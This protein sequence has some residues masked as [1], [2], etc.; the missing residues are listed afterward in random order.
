MTV[1]F[2]NH[3]IGFYGDFTTFALVVPSFTI[4]CA[5]GPA[6]NGGPDVIRCGNIM[7]SDIIGGVQ[8]D[9]LGGQS[10]ATKNGTMSAQAYC[11]EM[12][13]VQAFSWMLFC[14]NAIAL[15]ILFRLVIQAQMFGRFDIWNEP[16]RAGTCSELPWFGEAPGFYNTHQ[17]PMMPYPGGYP[18]MPQPMSATHPGQTIIVQPGMNGQ[19]ATVTTVP[20][21]A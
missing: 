8:C 17:G 4:L 10:T 1:R 9:A 6:Q 2:G 7:D 11:Y 21:P 12:K 16:I 5:M 14:I 3:R 15:Y 20:M 13:V 19:P 18:Y